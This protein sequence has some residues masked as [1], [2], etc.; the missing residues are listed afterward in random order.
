LRTGERERYLKLAEE[1]YL[2]SIELDPTYGKPKI[3]LG[4]L[5]TFNTDRAP[6]ALPHLER[7]MQ[8]APNDIRGMFVTARAYYMTENYGRAV[9]LYNRILSKTK[10][11]K[12]K[13]EAQNNIDTIR[14]LM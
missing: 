2:R 6:E 7:Y 9:D 1:S 13:A 4:I 10:D 14:E 8:I 3:G 5:Y 12:V 11:P